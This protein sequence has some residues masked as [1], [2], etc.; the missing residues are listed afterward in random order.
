FARLLEK[1]YLKEADPVRGRFRSFLLAC[2]SH[3]L[4]N[5][6]NRERA[7]EAWW[8]FRLRS[9]RSRQN[10]G[11]PW[12]RRARKPRRD[13]TNG[14]TLFRFS[15]RYRRPCAGSTHRTISSIGSKNWLRFSRRAIP[16][17]TQ[18]SHA[19]GISPK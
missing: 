12:S 18:K 9:M 10:A 16:C 2:V 8:G 19:N 17:S 4:S 14:S 13:Y 3:F 7:T 11:I 15:I 6:W 5:E 1:N